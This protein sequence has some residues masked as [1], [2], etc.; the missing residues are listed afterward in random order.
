MQGW[1]HRDRKG[2]SLL[3][4]CY[5]D[6]RDSLLLSTHLSDVQKGNYDGGQGQSSSSKKCTKMNREINTASRLGQDILDFKFHHVKD[7]K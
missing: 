4:S 6:I 7:S 3:E 1:R 5:F 2:V